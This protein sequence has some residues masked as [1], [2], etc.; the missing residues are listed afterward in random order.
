MDDLSFIKDSFGQ[1]NG[2]LTFIIILTIIAAYLAIKFK[3]DLVNL[4]NTKKD[5]RQVKSL[6]Y[7][8]MFLVCDKVLKRMDSIDFT[9]FNDYDEIKTKL[10]NK[11]IELKIKT[12]K[13]RFLEFLQNEKLDKMDQPQLK[14]LVA[15]TLSD[16]VNEYNDKAI[17][18]MSNEMDI[19]IEDAKFVVDQYERFREYIVNAFIDELDVIVMDD[20][21]KNNFDRINTILYTVSISLS[22]IPRDVVA[23]FNNI[24]GRFKKYNT[25][26]QL[27]G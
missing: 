23:T 11:L 4:V 19:K 22:I 5:N 18:I 16:L 1:M 26:N 20:N 27:Q 9:T 17:K 3:D 13:K 7:H 14:Y 10:L 21:Y 12:V 25:V 15:S 8:S 2:F 6:C 24:N